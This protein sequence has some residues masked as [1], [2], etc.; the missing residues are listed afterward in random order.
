MRLN[1]LYSILVE[2]DS[3]GIPHNIPSARYG[4]WEINSLGFRGKEVNLEK[5]EGQ[6]RI[7]CFGVSE[8][9]GF[10]ES[11]DKEWPSQLGEILSNKFPGAEVINASVVGLNLKKNKDFSPMTLYRWVNNK[12]PANFQPLKRPSLILAM[13]SLHALS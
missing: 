6:I 9:F 11:K 12:S 5:K 7:L 10:Y 3:H 2:V 8:T 1:D 4:K 13:I